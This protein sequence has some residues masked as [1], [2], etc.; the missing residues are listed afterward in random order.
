MSVRRRCASSEPV[1]AA[2]D[3]QGGIPQNFEAAKAKAL[4]V[5]AKKFFLEVC[6]SDIG[7]DAWRLTGLVW[8]LRISGKSSSLS[9]STQQSKL[10]ASM[11]Y[12]SYLSPDLDKFVH[13]RD[14]N[15]Y[16]LGTSLAR[17][18]IARGMMEV[19]DREGCE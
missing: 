14:Q 4:K 8:R 7:P 16:L 11:K 6:C 15:V 9:S 17:P 5:G 10:I 1:L 19:A 18:V 2:I 13:T 3:V 12:A